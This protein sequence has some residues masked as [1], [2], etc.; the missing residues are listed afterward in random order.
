MASGGAPADI[1]GVETFVP[2]RLIVVDGDDVIR[3]IAELRVIAGSPE[4]ADLIA[5]C[6]E[7]LELFRLSQQV[8]RSRVRMR[9]AALRRG[10]GRRG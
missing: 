10:C 8:A 7:R 5:G 1:C 6:L 4:H 2:S 3:R 9:R